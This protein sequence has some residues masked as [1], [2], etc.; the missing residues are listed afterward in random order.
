MTQTPMIT[1][2]SQHRIAPLYLRLKDLAAA[3][4]LSLRTINRLRRKVDCRNRTQF[5]D[6][7]LCFRP[8]TIQRW[9]DCGGSPK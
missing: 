4:S 1:T 9:V 2:P 6:C 8:S 7:A 5:S 3:T